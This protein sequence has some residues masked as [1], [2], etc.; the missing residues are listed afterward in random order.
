M[1]RIV[2]CAVINDLNHDRRMH[3]ICR[4]LTQHGYSVTLIGRRLK[5]SQ[6]IEN[7]V[8]KQH[9][10]HC[11]FSRGALFYIEYNLRL[12]IFLSFKKMDILNSID[13]DTLPALGMLSKIRGKKLIHDAHEYFTEVPEL[14]QKPVKK[15]IWKWV[16]RMFI[17][18]SAAA[19]TVSPSIAEAYSKMYRVPFQV[20]CN[21]PNY[22]PILTNEPGNRKQ[23]IY[24]GA[25][26]KGRGLEQ[27]IR[28]MQ[29]VDAHLWIAG[30]GDLSLALRQLVHSLNLYD[31]IEFLGLLS[32]DELRQTTLKASIGLNICE[33][34]GLSYQYA[35]SNKGFDYFHAGIPAITNDF[36]EYQRLNAEFETMI[37]V[38]CYEDDIAMAIEKLTSDNDFYERLRKNC[39]LAAQVYN[40]QIEE[41]K[42]LACYDGTFA[43][44]SSI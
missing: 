7:K 39:L 16:E 34:F 44:H 30:E 31:K 2:Y 28:A 21:A 10:I 32:P 42:L 26:N 6:P 41:K 37:L 36:I 1:E 43:S 3:R 5:H 23:L 25:L 29:K 13:A 18:G 27:I 35:L 20:V 38:N 4:S 14:D 11:L 40:W 9:R 15:Y 17:P 33:P 19:Y 12:F 24:Q 22:E 8:F